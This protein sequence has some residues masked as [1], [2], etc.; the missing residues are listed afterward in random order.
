[1][2]RGVSRFAGILC[3][4]LAAACGGDADPDPD[5]GATADVTT[6]TDTLRDAPALALGEVT[7][8]NATVSGAKDTAYEGGSADGDIEAFGGCS[9][10]SP[11][12]LGFNLTDADSTYL[13]RFRADTGQ[14][15]QPGET[16]TFDVERASFWYRRTGL[17]SRTTFEGTGTLAITRHDARRGARRMHGR[18]VAEGLEDGHGDVVNIE[19]QFE[20]GLSCGIE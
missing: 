12:R 16:G 7:S 15:L 13:A 19:V 9:A 8:F 5:P 1:M 4:L 2:P 20:L 3:F 17:P 11:L 14:L 18:L 10:T 6:L